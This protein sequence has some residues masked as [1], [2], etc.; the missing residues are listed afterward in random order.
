VLRRTLAVLVV[1]LPVLALAGW[2]T[3]VALAVCLVPCL[4][5]TAGALALGTV[6]GVGRAAL[7]L[8]ALWV[9]A[10]IGPSLVTAQPSVLLT[11]ASLPAW[12]LAAAMAVAVLT[13]RARAFTSLPGTGLA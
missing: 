1:M 7:S 13:V 10:V 6:F 12:G 11:P 8:G 4:A 2:I 3:G 5:F 9:L